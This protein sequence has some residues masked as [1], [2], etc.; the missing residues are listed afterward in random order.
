[1][2]STYELIYGPVTGLGETSRALLEYGRATWTPVDLPWADAVKQSPYGRVPVLR[3]TTADGRV[4]VLVESRAIERY[5]AKK[6][7]LYGSNDLEAARID[8]YVSQWEDLRWAIVTRWNT[9]EGG[10]GEA[11]AASTEKADKEIRHLVSKHTQS[12]AANAE[13]G[14][15]HYVGRGTTW[16]DIAAYQS[17]KLLG[18]PFVSQDKADEYREVLKAFDPLVQ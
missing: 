12:L 10:N 18:M 4:H 11:R 14:G 1:M 5:L 2:A 9:P 3:E 16:A 17:I 6:F 7:G 15:V 8:A 13:G